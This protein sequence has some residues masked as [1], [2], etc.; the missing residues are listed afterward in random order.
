M[1]TFNTPRDA[2]I[3]RKAVKDAQVECGS[4]VN[5]YHLLLLDFLGQDHLVTEL[6]DGHVSVASFPR[7]FEASEAFDECE[8]S[9]AEFADWI[10]STRRKQLAAISEL[11]DDSEAWGHI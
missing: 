3:Y 9:H 1:P 8:R 4:F 2:T 10:N 7:G 6:A 5:C 11:S